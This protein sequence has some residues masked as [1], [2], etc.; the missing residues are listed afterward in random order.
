MVMYDL[1]QAKTDF[2]WTMVKDN[3]VEPWREH[4]EGWFDHGIPQGWGDVIHRGLTEI[5]KILERF[6]AR[7]RIAIAQVKEKWG[8]LRFY[9]DLFAPDGECVYADNEC[10]S[11]VYDAVTKMEDETATVCCY[12]GTTEN[13][14]CYGGW[15]HYACEDCEG[16]A[17]D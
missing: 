11:L 14:E 1:K 16:K 2:P 15:A 10:Y 12:C 7:D 13:V 6:D 17:H 5:D 4:N 8:S 9:F 3:S